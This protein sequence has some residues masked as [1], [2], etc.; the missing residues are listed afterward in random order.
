MANVLVDFSR[1]EFEQRV[2]P[3]YTDAIDL[4]VFEDGEWVTFYDADGKD[5]NELR[6]AT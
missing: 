1:F 6:E 5:L 4:E 2:K 3:D